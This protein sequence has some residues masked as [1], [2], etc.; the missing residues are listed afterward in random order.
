MP[1][2]NVHGVCLNVDS[3]IRIGDTVFLDFGV[4]SSVRG[5]EAIVTDVIR[6][7]FDRKTPI[8]VEVKMG[9]TGLPFKLSPNDV[10]KPNIH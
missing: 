1:E 3:T 10:Y 7:C 9:Q 2:F 8:A 6:D 5:V 4:G